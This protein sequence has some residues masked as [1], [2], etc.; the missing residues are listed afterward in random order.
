MKPV[1][2]AP[3]ADE[4]AETPANAFL[5]TL[6]EIANG[7][8][9]AEG[10]DLLKEIHDRLSDT[11]GKAILTLKLAFKSGG[12]GQVQI[13]YELTSKTPKLAS[14]ISLAYLSG[15]G[16]FLRNDPKQRELPFVRSASEA[17]RPRIHSAA[18]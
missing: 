13:A 5:V 9:S 10:S 14:P 12:D 2:P 16:R 4:Q 3:K 18:S 7:G 17:E 11:P 15:D 1:S 8:L 6:A